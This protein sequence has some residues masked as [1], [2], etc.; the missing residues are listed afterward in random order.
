MEVQT[1]WNSGN[2]GEIATNRAD[3]DKNCK[4]VSMKSKELEDM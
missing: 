1:R 3:N 2:D 4:S